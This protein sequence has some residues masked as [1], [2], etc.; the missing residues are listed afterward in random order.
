M[1][2]FTE[3]CFKTGDPQCRLLFKGSHIPKLNLSR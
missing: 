1:P 2:D 3:L